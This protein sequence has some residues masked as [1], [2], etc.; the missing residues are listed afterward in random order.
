M[1]ETR[2]STRRTRY[3]S[4]LICQAGREPVMHFF[5][6]T[7]TEFADTTQHTGRSNVKCKRDQRSDKL[8]DM[9]LYTVTPAN[10]F[11]HNL[12]NINHAGHLD[13]FGSQLF[14]ILHFWNR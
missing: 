6:T 13:M 14:G 3:E 12:A 11:D 7:L 5:G 8:D 10:T 9:N 2:P 1:L 4:S